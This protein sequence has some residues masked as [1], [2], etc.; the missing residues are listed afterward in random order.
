MKLQST[1]ILVC[2]LACA[3]MRP[4]AA[5]GAGESWGSYTV[6]SRTA[7]ALTASRR[8]VVDLSRR[9]SSRDAGLLDASRELQ[10][11]QLSP[12]PGAT[13]RTDRSLDTNAG[14]TDGSAKDPKAIR[15]PTSSAKIDRVALRRCIYRAPRYGPRRFRTV[16]TPRGAAEAALRVQALAP[17]HPGLTINAHPRLYYYLSEGVS[18]LELT[19]ASYRQPQPLLELRLNEAVGP[20]MHELDLSEHGVAL[21]FDTEYEWH[22]AVVRDPKRRSRD[23]VSRG[24]IKRIRPDSALAK[25]I[26]DQDAW[27]K[28]TAYAQ[29]GLWYDALESLVNLRRLHPEDPAVS[30]GLQS[31]L[32]QAKLEA[33]PLQ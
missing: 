5:T 30:E 17:D 15:T 31:L 1:P 33:V 26:Q 22:V 13:N 16:S 21:P 28:P 23:V 3:V 4:N 9:D 8:E 18:Q 2:A 24:V 25:E 14:T 7:P 10:L 27:R 19:L 29:A 6:V 20:G 12:P 32:T 11:T